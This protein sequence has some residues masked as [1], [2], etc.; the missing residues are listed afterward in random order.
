MTETFWKIEANISVFNGKKGIVEAFKEFKEKIKNARTEARTETEE[1]NRNELNKL[2]LE[3][4]QIISESAGT[5][6]HARWSKGYIG[7][8]K[9]KQI[10]YK[11]GWANQL[12]PDL[13]QV[14]F[15][16]NNDDGE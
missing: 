2:I 3:R 12:L 15:K 9:S 10:G 14:D 16:S 6:N 4:W 8:E 5:K 13:F 7:L 1:E 11:G